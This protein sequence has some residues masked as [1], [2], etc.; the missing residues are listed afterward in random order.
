MQIKTHNM[1]K[2]KIGI[3][4]LTEAVVKVGEFVSTVDEVLEDKKVNWRE[5]FKLGIQAP[6][7]VKVLI[8]WPEIK[9]EF[10]DLSQEERTVITDIFVQEF[11][12]RNDKTEE[13]V[14][15][16]F[17]WLLQFNDLRDLIQLA[18]S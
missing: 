15:Q 18:R 9:R 17:N 2:E 8:Q 6:A 3:S 13:I 12:L 16:L 14:E 5:G 4:T 10:Q 11:N 1:K 7:L